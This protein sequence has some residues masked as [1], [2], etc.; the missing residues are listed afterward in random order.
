VTKDHGTTWEDATIP[1]LENPTRADISA[2]DASHQDP[3]TAYVAI[4]YHNTADYKPYFYR[5]HDFGKTWTKIVNGLPT[6]LPSGSFSRV[7][8]ADTKKSGLIFAGTESFVYVSFND[9]DT[10]QS[11]ALNLPNT[12][13][14][15]MVVKDN[16]LVV[17]TYGRGFWV[18]DDI[19]PLRQIAASMASESAHLFKPG[20]AVRVRRNVNGDTPFPPEIP[21]AL[22]PPAGALI[23]YY[24]GAK[25]AGTLTI[26]I[27]NAAGKIVR[28]M[29]S[30]A[31]NLPSE[32]PPPVPDFW[33]QKPKPLPTELGTNRINWDLRCD[34]PPAFNHSYQ[35]NANPGETP[36]SPEGPLVPP[37]EYTVTLAVDGKSYKQSVTVK[38]DPRSPASAAD[39]KS[40][41]E[42][43]M[44]LYDAVKQAYEGYEQVAA[45]RAAAAE[46]GK[47]NT[48]AD[49]TDAVS[50][51]DTKLAAVGGSNGGGRRFGG[52]FGGG[53]GSPTFVAVHGNL[54]RQLEQLDS[55]DMR[56][57][58]PIAKSTLAALSQFQKVEAAWQAL[59]AK[60]LAAFNAVLAK[61]NQKPIQA[62]TANM[63]AGR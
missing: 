10:W 32:P 46:A 8:R 18:L 28:H 52:G 27:A 42:L 19:S 17:G 41:S 37:G 50:A 59:N 48:A 57:N 14:R 58:E 38:N 35:I 30:A 31:L 22:N 23:Y 6:D 21:H 39:L 2:I 61:Y 34:N 36:M 44:K 40:Q 9:G 29:S 33:I 1:G 12:S 11:L 5:T 26:E 3:G 49:L 47:G 4:D 60:D 15:D 62:A 20:D 54:L 13:Y 7:I 53:G 16:D 51:F 55:G 63:T 43:Q 45:M 25:A 56:P 24:L